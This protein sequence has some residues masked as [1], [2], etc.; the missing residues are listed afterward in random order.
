MKE[1]EKED[2]RFILPLK[3]QLILVLMRLRLGLDGMDLAFSKPAPGPDFEKPRLTAA[4]RNQAIWGAMFALFGLPGDLEE[5][6]DVN[7]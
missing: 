2:R 4:A 5:G 3:T 7:D 6:S 1:T